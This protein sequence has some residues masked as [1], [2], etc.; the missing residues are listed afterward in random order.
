MKQKNRTG[1]SFLQGTAT[2]R[3]QRMAAL[4]HWETSPDGT[5]LITSCRVPSLSV[6]G[7]LD[8]LIVEWAPRMGS[9]PVITG[10]NGWITVTFVR[11]GGLTA[12]DL[13]IAEQVE[14][15]LVAS[16]LRRHIGFAE[17]VC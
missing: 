12:E 11:P 2:A 17:E 6:M 13:A 1:G 4:P 7:Q 9:T 15:I 14:V 10:G 5:K 16:S 3:L 8:A